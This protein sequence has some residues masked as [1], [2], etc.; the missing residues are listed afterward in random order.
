ML[1]RRASRVLRSSMLIVG[2]PPHLPQFEVF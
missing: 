1:L 2:R